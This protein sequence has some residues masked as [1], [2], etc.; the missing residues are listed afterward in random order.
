MPG[1][2]LRCPGAG[3]FEAGNIRKARS[4]YRDESELQG[5]K[6]NTMFCADGDN[7]VPIGAAG[8]AKFLSARA[9]SVRLA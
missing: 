4:G 9:A 8:F 3:S 5:P 1:G 7:P 2:A 6:V